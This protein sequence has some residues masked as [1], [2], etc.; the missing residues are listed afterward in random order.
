M[1]ALD[2]ALDSIDSIVH[3]YHLA[4]TTRELG[5]LEPEARPGAFTVIGCL[6]E[7]GAKAANS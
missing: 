5:P 2:A 7:Y 4:I 3:K 6:I 1:S